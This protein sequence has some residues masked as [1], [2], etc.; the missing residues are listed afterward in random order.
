MEN[1]TICGEFAI[2]NQ[3]ITKQPQIKTRLHFLWKK[4]DAGP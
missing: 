2:T 4:T 1:K 3:Y